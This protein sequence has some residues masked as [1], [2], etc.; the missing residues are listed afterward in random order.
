M[1]NKFLILFLSLASLSFAQELTTMPQ[2]IEWMRYHLRLKPSHTK[3]AQATLY[4]NWQDSAN[5]RAATVDIPPQSNDD[6]MLGFSS[7]YTVFSR[8]NGR[9]SIMM[10][11]RFDAKYPS[12]ANNGMSIIL[13]HS[14]GQSFLNFGTTKIAVGG[15][16][17][18]NTKNPGMIGYSSTIQLTELRN[19]V[20]Y[21]SGHALE[22]S[23][24]KSVDDLKDYLRASTDSI[25]GIWQYFDRIT[26]PGESQLGGKYTLATVRRS[27]GVYDIIYLAGAKYNA[28]NWQPLDIKGVLRKTIF[29]RHFDLEWVDANLNL[30]DDECSAT[31][32]SGC[33]MLQIDLPLDQA[34]L[35]F[36]RCPKSQW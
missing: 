30:A 7:N 9:D 13:H 2:A 11:G 32:E 14:D 16:V 6:A 10:S 22:S 31:Y 34:S 35:R 27:Q 28:K 15:S 20:L 19:K 23:R 29:V 24:F 4:W 21:L 1:R 18:I 3:S 33:N 12:S 26:K 36:S 5:F 8:T 17:V 25:E